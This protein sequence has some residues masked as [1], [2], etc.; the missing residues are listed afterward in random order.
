MNHGIIWI[1]SSRTERPARNSAHRGGTAWLNV[2]K[3]EINKL[4]PK[5]EQITAVNLAGRGRGM[6]QSTYSSTILHTSPQPTIPNT[7]PHTHR[8]NSK[9]RRGQGERMKS[10]RMYLPK[11][12]GSLVGW[13][14]VFFLHHQIWIQIRIKIRIQFWL[15]S[16]RI[17][18][19][20][21]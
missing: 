20:Y 10:T 4:Y 12:C 17:G 16:Y 19:Q 18:S 7:H 6:L 2:F 14:G 11:Y 3:Y 8:S 21:L 15:L 9:V 13:S 1:I 5:E